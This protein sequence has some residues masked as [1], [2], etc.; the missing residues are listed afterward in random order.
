MR[1]NNL[2]DIII[3]IA[4]ILVLLGFI[5]CIGYTLYLNI[6]D[7]KKDTFSLLFLIDMLAND[8]LYRTGFISI[9]V[10]CIMFWIVSDNK[11]Q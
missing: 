4:I 6:I 1:K 8:G 9:I 10:G 3:R 2:Q 7:F 11:S 5:I